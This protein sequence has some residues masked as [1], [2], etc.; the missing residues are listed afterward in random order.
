MGTLLQ[1]N[2]VDFT[3][4]I[5][6]RGLSELEKEVARD[7][8]VNSIYE[9]CGLSCQFERLRSIEMAKLAGSVSNLSRRPG[10][11]VRQTDQADS[12][13]DQA[14]RYF[15]A[16]R[17][18]SKMHEHS[19]ALRY[20]IEEVS[21]LYDV[22]RFGPLRPL[23]L[24]DAAIMFP[25]SGMGFPV[26]SSNKEGTENSPEWSGPKTPHFMTVY[27][28]SKEIWDGGA[29]PR[30]IGELMAVSGYRGQ[31]RKKVRSS[32]SP[33]PAW[34]S[35][36]RLIYM[37][38]RVFANIEK[39]IQFILFNAL[40]ASSAPHFCAWRGDHAV[41][42]AMT[43]LLK[44][45]GDVLS[46]DFK[47]FDQSVPFEVI[48]I[49]FDIICSWFTAESHALIRFAQTGFKRMGLLTPGKALRS[50]DRT[51]GVPSGSVNTNTIGTIVNLLVMHYAAHRCKTRVS[52]A[53]PMGDDGVYRFTRP[54]TLEALAH[55]VH[56]ELG[57]TIA[58]D[59]TSFVSGQVYFLQ[60]LHS[61]DYEVGGLYVGVR[62]IMHLA[63]PMT[64]YERVDAKNEKDQ[65][66]KVRKNPTGWHRD[67]D[68]IRWLQQIAQGASHPCATQMCD[69]LYDH[70]WCLR[71][72]VNRVMSNDMA[73]IDAATRAVQRKDGSLRFLGM[74]SEAF[75]RSPVLSYLARR[76]R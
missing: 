3:S 36:T 10:F 22:S 49:A 45:G 9:Y 76:C 54:V 72:V 14:G 39:T 8:V 69:W 26:M 63:I 37:M 18:E 42:V 46:L 50:E 53:F 75:M 55:C 11:H 2:S 5:I 21:K 68:T 25:N 57:M 62:P 64:S 1:G 35:K 73:F 16:A 7:R 51:G 48:D 32:T 17:P 40:R 33:R 20:A 30:W 61:I 74:S 44:K 15:D 19:E 28:L 6:P 65:V 43:A 52:D 47:G 60:R 23:N 38:P 41:D 27:N 24:C 59:K 56:S 13:A 31:P 4:A 34:Y 67:Y 70:D 66:G 12:L 71:K 29:D 58:Q